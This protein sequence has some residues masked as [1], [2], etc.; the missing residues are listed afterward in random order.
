MAWPVKEVGAQAGLWNSHKKPNAHI[1]KSL[2]S[3]ADIGGRDQI[4]QELRPTTLGQS[5]NRTSLRHQ[6]EGENSLP[7]P[8]S[9]I[10][11]PLM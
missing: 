9:D 8:S 6:V 3:A 10:H 4:V 1:C 5:Q 7:R 2:V 11:M